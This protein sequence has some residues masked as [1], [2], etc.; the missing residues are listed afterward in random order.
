M[1]LKDIEK[2]LTDLVCRAILRKCHCQGNRVPARIDNIDK[3]PV[4]LPL[5]GLPE[6]ARLQGLTFIPAQPSANL[7]L[8]ITAPA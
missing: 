1:Y 2:L 6:L 7:S 4:D 3:Q 5:D 8:W